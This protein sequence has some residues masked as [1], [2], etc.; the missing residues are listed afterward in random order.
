MSA[1][2]WTIVDSA[3]GTVLGQTITDGAQPKDCGFEGWND[4]TMLAVATARQGDPAS[5][6]FDGTAWVPDMAV[7][8]GRAWDAVKVKRDAVRYGGCATPKGLVQTDVTSWT[9]LQGFAATALMVGPTYSVT[10]IMADNSAVLHSHDEIIA[11]AVAVSQFYAACQTV[12]DGLRA[13]IDA[14]ASPEDLAAI[15][16]ESAA[17]PS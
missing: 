7:L 2:N 16:I 9:I 10:Y 8:R 13:Q 1:Q 6:M 12:S 14:A 17:W 4:A 5:E 3:T 15:D 11:A